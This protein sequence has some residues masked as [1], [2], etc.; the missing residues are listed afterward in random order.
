IWA[1]DLDGMEELIQPFNKAQID[2]LIK[3][4]QAHEV[5]VDTY[6]KQVMMRLIPYDG[7]GN[8]STIPGQIRSKD[9]VIRETIS[10]RMRTEYDESSNE[11][12]TL[13]EASKEKLMLIVQKGAEEVAP[14]AMMG[15]GGATQQFGITLLDRADA[16]TRLNKLNPRYDKAWRS[17]DAMKTNRAVGSASKFFGKT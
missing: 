12:F 8:E 1:V 9:G 6:F 3:V 17:L 5:V 14:E 11:F 7:P 4:Q 16:A 13:M 10:Q 15:A 2:R